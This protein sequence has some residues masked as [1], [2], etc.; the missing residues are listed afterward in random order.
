M[1]TFACLFPTSFPPLVSDKMAQWV[2]LTRTKFTV[3]GFRVSHAVFHLQLHLGEK[4]ISI[5][6]LGFYSFHLQRAPGFFGHEGQNF[7]DLHYSPMVGSSNSF[8]S[9]T[10]FIRTGIIQ[11]SCGREQRYSSGAHVHSGS[12]LLR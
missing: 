6:F 3:P 11:V 12:C 9:R 8:L 1:I 7:N 10:C 4:Y 5:V 2:A